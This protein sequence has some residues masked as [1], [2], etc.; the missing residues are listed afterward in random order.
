M[1]PIALMLLAQAPSQDLLTPMLSRGPLALVE[2]T[3]DGKFSQATSVV[4]VNAPLDRVWQTVLAQEKFKTFMPKVAESDVTNANDRGFDVRLVIEVPGPDTDYIIHYARDDEKHV[5]KG[6]W[7]K[8]DLKDSKWEWR[9]EPTAEGKT[10]LFH[11]LTVKNFSSILQNLEDDQQTITVGV[12][13][14]SAIAATKAVKN[15]VENA[16]AADA[17]T[18]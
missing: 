18:K 8:G 13:V 3:K 14:A 6:T 9:A 10:L 1:F 12:N 15:R 16:P 5:L 2:Q 4:M 11:Q 7:K 17:G